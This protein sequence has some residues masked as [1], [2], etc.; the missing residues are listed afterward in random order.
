L[1]LGDQIKKKEVGGACNTFE[2]EREEKLRQGLLGKPQGKG[3]LERG[4]GWRITLKL[5]GGQS[6]GTRSRNCEL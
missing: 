3:S 2:R 5:S 1:L 6:M 4:A